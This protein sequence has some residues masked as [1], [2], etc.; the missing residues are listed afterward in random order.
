M[1]TLVGSEG[2]FAVPP[3]ML[4][5]LT[6]VIYRRS[7]LLSH[8]RRFSVRQ[9]GLSAALPDETA[10]GD[11]AGI[12]VAAIAEMGEFPLSILK[13]RRARLSLHK[14]GCAFY[15]SEELADDGHD[16]FALLGEAAAV[17][18]RRKMER[19]VWRGSGVGQ[20]LGVIH[21]PCLLVQAIEGSQ[22]IANT[23]Q[24]IGTN[25]AK[26]VAQLLDLES[27]AF[28]VNPDLLTA[29]LSTTVNGNAKTV[30]TPPDADAPFGRIAT[31]PVFPNYAAPAVGAV[32]DFVAA[33]M[34]DYAVVT[35]GDIHSAMSI[36]VRFL[37][38][39]NVY[40]FSLRWDAQPLLSTAYVPE[41]STS[42]KSHY[43]ALA[44]R[45]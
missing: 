17:A 43:V 40:R 34:A 26:M 20:G 21:A 28:Y 38:G 9:T 23:A 8:V 41:W 31:R 19:T 11:F 5:V 44:A 33:S 32:G 27:A 30:L 12:E 3:E 45:A 1:N 18:M 4:T 7:H 24:H 36:H 25:A 14:D 22:T 42:K 16:S 6:E 35:K 13:T 15:V 10:G 2:G 39:E 37:E 29:L